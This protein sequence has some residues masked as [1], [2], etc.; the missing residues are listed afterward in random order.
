VYIL[1]DRLTGSIEAPVTAGLYVMLLVVG[2][3]PENVIVVEQPMQLYI[4]LCFSICHMLYFWWDMMHIA[5][6]S[7][8][9]E[10]WW[11][12]VTS[13]IRLTSN[14][15]LQCQPPS[16]STAAALASTPHV[17]SHDTAQASG[18]MFDSQVDLEMQIGARTQRG[19][20]VMHCSH[21]SHLRSL[22]HEQRT[23]KEVGFLQ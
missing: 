16:S 19:Y 11:T 4:A 17:A 2:V 9:W 12:E 20:V 22:H 21:F 15:K 7:L 1:Y 3:R 5:F 6:T 18:G 23:S 8:S 10:Q 13:P 14:R